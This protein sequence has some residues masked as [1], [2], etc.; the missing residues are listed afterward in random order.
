MAMPIPV[1]CTLMPMSASDRR[2]LVFAVLATSVLVLVLA[3]AGYPELLAFACPLLVVALPLVAGRYLG[4]ESIE[5]MRR[6]TTRPRTR[7]IEPQQPAPRGFAVL[8]RG[9]RLIAAALAERGP[10][11][12]AVS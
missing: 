6:R 8:P 5:R 2:L 1:L 12:L 7:R 4:E 11:A 10:P 3:A 9:G